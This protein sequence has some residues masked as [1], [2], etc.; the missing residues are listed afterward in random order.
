MDRSGPSTVL[1]GVVAE[2]DAI[3]FAQRLLVLLDEGRFSATYKYAVLLGL[4]ELCQEQGDRD[5]DAPE[6]V[7]TRQLAEK[8]VELY[9]PH[10]AEYPTSAGAAILRQNTQG[11]AEVLSRVRAFRVRTNTRALAPL[12]EARARDAKG[13]ERLVQSV[14]WKLVEMPLPR[15]QQIGDRQDR[16]VYQIYWESDVTAGAVRGGDFDNRIVFVGKAGSHL[17]RLAGLLR[18]LIQRQWSS[19]VARLNRDASEEAHLDEFLFGAT[20]IS[21]EPVRADLRDLQGNCCFYCGK[22]MRTGADVDHF[23]PWSRHPENAIENL[24][25]CHSACNGWK[26]S[27]LASHEHV[28]S[29]V[30]RLR[31]KGSVLSEAARLHTWDSGPQRTLSIARSIYFQLPGEAM[32]WQERKHFISADLATLRNTLAAAD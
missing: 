10:A 28:E 9:W 25:A 19:M 21:L 1:G 3:R 17:L 27:F 2:D 22:A 18:P 15:L 12:V 5:G 8:V 6:S 29:W 30:L 26:S 13:W 7:T 32:L 24:V 31:E 16:F 14:E 23:I 4:I 20:R 11:Q